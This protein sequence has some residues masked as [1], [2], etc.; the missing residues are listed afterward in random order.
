MT[1]TLTGAANAKRVFFG[2]GKRDVLKALS[3]EHRYRASPLWSFWHR[4]VYGTLGLIGWLLIVWLFFE[5]GTS[6]I[7]AVQREQNQRRLDQA[8]EERRLVEERNHAPML[9]LIPPER[10]QE[11]PAAVT[12]T[13]EHARAATGLLPQYPGRQ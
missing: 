3:V 13:A 2:D 6:L 8:T 4:V 11:A 10:T 12:P 7:E 5:V 9:R 1:Y